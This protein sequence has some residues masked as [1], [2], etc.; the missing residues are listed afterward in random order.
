MKV[1]LARGLLIWGITNMITGWAV[2]LF[3]WLG[4]AKAEI[5][6]PILNYI[7]VALCASCVV[8]SSFIKN[9]EEEKGE[10]PKRVSS[11]GNLGSAV[12]TAINDPE[13]VIKM[14]KLLDALEE[15]DD[16]QN[17]FHNWDMP[18]EPDEE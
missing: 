8:I 14:N 17:V 18:D 9:A 11:V 5:A 2:S 7:G 12:I 16:V 6:R 4:Q 13:L 1:G 15:N 10:I 3:G